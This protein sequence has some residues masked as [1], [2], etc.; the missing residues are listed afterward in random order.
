MNTNRGIAPLIILAILALLAV[1]GGTAVY[2]GGR[3]NAQTNN[4]VDKTI[5][6]AENEQSEGL[7]TETKTATI[8]VVEKEIAPSPK[9]E[10]KVEAKVAVS[11][12]RAP[13]TNV[14]LIATVGDGMNYGKDVVCISDKSTAGSK[15]VWRYLFSSRFPTVFAEERIYSQNKPDTEETIISI[16]DT[17][18]RQIYG[19]SI[20]AKAYLAPGAPQVTAQINSYAYCSEAT[21]FRT[22]GIYQQ[23]KCVEEPVP[24]S[25]FIPD[26]KL[27][28]NETP[29]N[30]V[31]CAGSSSGK[32]D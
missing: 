5:E 15:N 21:D 4:K 30:T 11:A 27:F 3:S 10:T 12:K 1:G 28:A 26:P 29:S 25:Y 13:V 8:P 14:S 20:H 7:K 9:V 16:N 24:D 18:K 2:V 31:V 23:L 17:A 19:I 6:V 22:G 32:G